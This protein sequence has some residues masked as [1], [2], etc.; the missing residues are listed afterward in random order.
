MMK[1]KTLYL[2][3]K[4]TLTQSFGRFLSIMSL[5]GLGAF[6]LVG[7]KVTGPDI[8]STVQHTLTQHR[9]ADLTIMADYGLSQEDV[10]ELKEIENS[11]FEF[12]YFSDTVIQDTPQAIR[13]FSQTEDISIY[14]LV[15]GSFPQNDNE[16]ALSST[17]QNNY[18]IGDIISLS[19][20]GKTP[21]LSKHSFKISGFITSNEFLSTNVL[22]ISTTGSGTLT[23]FAMVQPTVFNSDVYTIAR[24]RFMDLTPYNTFSKTYEN[25]IMAYEQLISEKL[26]DNGLYRLQHIQQ[27][28][29]TKMNDGQSKIDEALDELNRAQQQLDNGQYD[30]DKKQQEITNGL[31]TLAQND[32][33]LKQS[34][35]L[36]DEAQQ[37]LANSKKELDGGKQLLDDGLAQ[38]N[39]KKQLL[40]TTKKQLDQSLTTLT[41]TKTQLDSAKLQL[42]QLEQQIAQ[43]EQLLA[44]NPSL[45]S[46]QR[47][48]PAR[49]TQ[50]RQ[51]LINGQ[52]ELLINE[53]RYE[54]GKQQYDIG[55]EQYDL[56]LTQLAASQTLIEN[57][58]NEYSKGLQQYNNAFKNYQ[59]NL[60]R[61]QEG[62]EQLNH[63]RNTLSNGQNQLNEAQLILNANRETFHVEQAKA[64]KDITKAQQDI[65]NAQADLQELLEPKYH[66][67]TRSSALG[68]EGY[69][70]IQATSQ[71]ISS[72]GN[73]FP[74][75]LYGVAAL[76]TM[77]T[78]TRFVNEERTKAGILKALGYSNRDIYKKFII[79]GFISSTI[80]TIIGIIAGTYFLPYLLGE[81]LLATT[82]LPKIHLIFYWDVALIALLFSVVC[83]VAP[84]LWIANRE[85][86]ENAAKLLLPKPPANAATILLERIPFIWSRLSFT[87]KV[88]ARNIFRYKQRMFMT[89]FGVAGSLALLFSGLG[90]LSSL[91][92][93]TER[94]YGA[95]IQYDAL[96]AQH[97]NIREEK[98]SA[99]QSQLNNPQIKTYLPLFSTT[100]TQKIDGINTP[101]TITV[102][103]TQ[104]TFDGYINLFDTKNKQPLSLTDNGVYITEKLANQMHVTV[105]DTITLDDT[106]TLK[107]AGVVEMY[108]GHF[109]FM[110]DKAYEQFFNE[111][112][113]SNAY[114]L[115]FNNTSS[116]AI[117][118]ASAQFMALDGVKTVVQNT[119]MQKTVTTLVNSL[120]TVMLVLTAVSILLGVVIL[121]NLT[122]INVAERIRELST[123]KVL[124]FFNK[125]VTLYIYRETIILSAIGMLF[126]L[127]FGR[128]LHRLI[129]DTVATPIMMFNPTVDL[130]VYIVPCIIIASIV[131]ILGI[132]INHQLKN[133]DM[134]EALKSVE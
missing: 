62:I 26:K 1:K 131:A 91:S 12:G 125:E 76:V 15:S 103:S 106:Y 71:G 72:V 5:M 114:L 39:V 96:V 78:M 128:L 56:G 85:L 48:T 49:I 33:Q 77:T 83:S 73:M 98:I 88:T 64:T 101:Q 8:N 20:K 51:Q 55:K 4:Q 10:N 95:I 11:T 59:N 92:G 90:I 86:K 118:Q 130:W 32:N 75:V 9:S 81:T 120:T 38:L 121:Y 14:Q 47:I 67:Y 112:W 40:N 17:L 107:I 37:Q 84:A 110:N 122:T 7:L 60:T 108:A 113:Q 93:M 3:I 69:T 19:E 109:L 30:I 79:Y 89:I 16:I 21:L 27:I 66:V 87:Q 52:N 111:K 68:G 129:I 134:L 28:A 116:H 41:Q 102:L 124:G 127:F 126:G 65:A 80:G 61:Y 57:Q 133:V 2:D 97:H 54:Q 70:T 13:V 31:T 25:K 36:L 34:K 94:Q 35:Q 58:L 45:A 53:Q 43:A 24:L 23:G 63:A 22:G 117:Q 132:I 44:I 6:G 46:T 119:A 42:Q 115:N 74:V 104:T 123:I 105:G 99:I 18:N 29:H 82:I 100:Y 50:W